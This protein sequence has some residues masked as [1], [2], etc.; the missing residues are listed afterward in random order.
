MQCFPAR[1]WSSWKLSGKRTQRVLIGQDGLALLTRYPYMAIMLA[2]PALRGPGFFKSLQSFSNF[3][4]GRYGKHTYP[5]Q[6]RGWLAEKAS[7][8]QWQGM[9]LVSI[10]IGQLK[11][12]RVC[13]SKPQEVRLSNMTAAK[14]MVSYV[15]VYK[16]IFLLKILKLS[17]MLFA[18]PLGQRAWIR[19]FV[20]FWSRYS[21]C[22]D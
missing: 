22:F 9:S 18:P 6:S 21:L 12:V 7:C 19:W 13:Q 5:T 1:S 4:S 2:A 3:L 14:G 10:G 20:W 15:K 8:I 16:H 17:V 11:T